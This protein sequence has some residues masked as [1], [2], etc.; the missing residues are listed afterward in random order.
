MTTVNMTC[1]EDKHTHSLIYSV[2]FP[3]S[4]SLSVLPLSPLLAS[5]HHIYLSHFAE[6]PDVC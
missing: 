4:L 1:V 2:A 5:L 6:M 3:P